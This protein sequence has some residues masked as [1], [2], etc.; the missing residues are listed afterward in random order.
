MNYNVTTC[1]LCNNFMTFRQL[2]E[3]VYWLPDMD[4]MEWAWALYEGFEHRFAHR[5]CWKRLKEK[6]REML[7]HLALR[8]QE[9]RSMGQLV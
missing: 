5:F 4:Q 8:G 2:R 7:R 9:P 3:G 6:R 1:V